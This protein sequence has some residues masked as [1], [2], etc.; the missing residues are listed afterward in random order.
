MKT[1]LLIAFLGIVVS[2]CALQTVWVKPGATEYQFQNDRN[3]CL[4]I[5]NTNVRSKEEQERQEYKKSLSRDGNSSTQ[6]STSMLGYSIGQAM[7]RKANI[8]TAMRHCM[9]SRGYS[10]KDAAPTEPKHVFSE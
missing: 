6:I 7:S 2:G 10:D 8:D 1:N 5:A 3:Q 9:M 4:N